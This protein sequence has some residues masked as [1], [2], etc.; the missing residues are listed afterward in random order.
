[1]ERVFL[2]DGTSLAYRAFFAIKGLS[3]SKGFP[4][5][6][7]YGFVRIFLKF[8]KELKPNYVAVAFD[9]GRKTFRSELSKD[10]K[11]NRRPT[12]DDFKLQLPYIKRF[13]KCLGVKV[14]E[15]PGYEADDILGT[16][17]EKLSAQKVNVVIITPDK[18]MRQLVKENVTVVAISNRTGSSKTYD[19]ETF[20]REYGV[21]P[22]Q[23]PDV[24]G[25]SGDSVD[26]IPGVPG[27]G[28]KTALKLIKEFGSIENLY[29]NLEVLPEKRR[30]LLKKFKE[31]A[32]LSKELA[33]IKTD[34]PIELNLEEL[35]VKPPDE[36][37]LKEIINELEMR[38]VAKELR[39]LFPNLNLNND[40]EEGK[41]LSKAEL[42]DYLSK[43]DLFSRP[44]LL[45][46]LDFNSV[47]LATPEGYCEVS[48][49][50]ALEFLKRAWKVYGFN[51]KEL[52][53][54]FNG[55]LENVNLEDVSLLYYLKN[56]ILKDYSA[57]NLLKEHLKTFNL[58]P[59]KKYVHHSFGLI[60][61]LKLEIRN[62][63]LER[64]YREI[65]L[66]LC[67]VL[68]EMEKR[69]VLFDRNYL[70]ELGK[71]I[72]E[73]MEELQREIYEEAGEEFNLNSPKQLSQILFEK[74]GL[75]PI[76]KTKSGYS[77]DVETLVHLALNGN[78][79]AEYL[80]EYRKLSKLYGTYV[81]GLLK[82]IKEDGRVHGKFLQTATATG[83]LSSAEPN[84]QNLPASDEFSQR[85][86]K[87]VI[88]PLGCNLV[89]ADYS[90]VEL[91]ILAHM[92]GDENLIE[93]FNSGK[94]I[95][96][97]TAKFIFGTEEV[98]ERM[99]RVAKTVNFGIIYGMSPHGLSERLGIS[100]EE[101][102]KYIE[103]YF[104]KFPKVKE[105]IDKTVKEAY[106]RGYVRT[107]FGRIRPL[108]ELLSSNKNLRNFG[109][110][111]AVNATIQGT[112]ADIMK[113]AMVRLHQKLKDLQGFMTI[114]VHDEI[115]AEVPE[116]KTQEAAE[117][118]RETMENCVKLKVP[119]KVEVK[120]GKRWE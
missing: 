83:R 18:D 115:V 54:F 1:M 49:E 38:S 14:L 113:L 100:L 37:C 17:A 75:K 87:A 7:V 111:A 4:T 67:R 19:L 96:F 36:K 80:L 23:L 11:A 48:K 118:I 32:F 34:V 102:A 31:Q 52:Y 55:G 78:R 68:Y 103:N 85:I 12:P 81:K 116:E 95:H 43:G 65:E 93:A 109:E 63:G 50:E 30:E 64:L 25:L 6:A 47:V 71:E 90:Q 3:T 97:E 33:K 104:N 2:F 92:S 77:T 35:K 42:E 10:Y 15:K 5:N 94:D 20:R 110:R 53:H 70:E 89:W 98:D 120:T 41:E 58:S 61:K 22:Y 56:P 114:Q 101:A 107:L 8:F 40:A 21:E 44:E 88:S 73:K 82:H 39:K 86:R 79:I 74:L 91:R 28:E 13:L 117:L 62:L 46:F 112:A 16:L 45:V 76:K 29:E 24:F 51:V 27:I 72:A 106:E 66:P 99:R 59:L 108:P 69:G 57:E 84:L 105:Y 26:N 60:E 119:L 9:A